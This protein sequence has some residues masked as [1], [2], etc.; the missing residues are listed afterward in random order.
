METSDSPAKQGALVGDFVGD[1]VVGDFDGF[2]V[3]EGVQTVVSYNGNKK[4][5]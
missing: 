5:R 2:I 4:L 1:I 3:G